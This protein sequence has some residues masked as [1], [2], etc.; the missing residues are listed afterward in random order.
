VFDKIIEKLRDTIIEQ[1]QELVKIKHIFNTHKFK[2][3]IIFDF[4]PEFGD[5]FSNASYTKGCGLSL[6]ET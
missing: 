2:N 6:L 3:K 4:I 1:T 5:T